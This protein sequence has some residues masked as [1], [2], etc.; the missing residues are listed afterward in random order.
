MASNEARIVL[1]LQA[2]QRNEFRSVRAATI[3]F[4]VVPKT[5]GRRLRGTPSKLDFTSPHR[6]LTS[7]EETTIVNWIKSI[8]QRGM[9]PTQSLIH[10]MAE[11]LLKQHV[12]SILLKLGANWVGRFISRYPDLRM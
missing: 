3:A 7:T 11:I 9:P 1:A 12:G 2:Y 8:D 5:L 4:E 10:Q 6:K